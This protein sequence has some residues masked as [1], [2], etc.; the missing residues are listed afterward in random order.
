MQLRYIQN[1]PCIIIRVGT[2]LEKVTPTA[3]VVAQARQRVNDAEAM[4][5]SLVQSTAEA[6]ASLEAALL[7]GNPTAPHR[8]ELKNITEL[9]ADQRHEISQANADIAQVHQLL[10]HHA[11]TRIR[12]ADSDALAALVK[13][14]SDFLETQK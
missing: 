7:K 14:F 4:L 8:T 2:K 10:D 3:D 9:V 12:L 5:A 11:A 13:P 1:V 6:Q